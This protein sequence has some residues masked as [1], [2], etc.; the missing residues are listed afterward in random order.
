[1]KMCEA[2][3][4][5]G[6]KITLIVPKRFNPITT[7]L[8][9]YYMVRESAR[10]NISVHEISSP[11]LMMFG[12]IGFIIQTWIFA[13]LASIAMRKVRPD[14]IYSRDSSVLL[15]MILIH[16]HLIWEVHQ[17]EKRIG[18]RLLLIKAG[19]VTISQGLAD[20]YMDR[21]PKSHMCVARDAVD[22]EEFDIS[23][24]KEE[25]R[26]KVGLPIEARIALYA[27]HLYSWKGADVFAEASKDLQDN[28]YAVCVGG[29]ER[30]VIEFKRKYGD[31][32]RLMILGRKPHANI[33][34]YLRSADVLILPNSALEKI[35]SHY[36]SPLKLFEYMA[37]STPIVASDLP[38]LR[39]VLDDSTTVFVKPDNPES[40]T[41]GIRKV[42]DTD[43]GQ[44]LAHNAYTKV[45]GMTWSARAKVI[46]DF[47]T[48][49]W[50][51]D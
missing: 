23:L 42:L 20:L 47:I 39:E 16:P 38:S 36:T 21:V 11:N 31:N 34:L 19:L 22:I 18:A 51:I 25:C 40:L 9:D 7:A 33:P 14:V 13:E 43:V 28:E 35:S 10:P 8:F 12:K 30:D 4:L 26:R 17:S 29:T 2:F 27:G 49:L 6:H 3:A 44:E 24:S 45:K 1:M 46:E 5:H 50:N 15:N 37:S 32:P 41:L 48:K